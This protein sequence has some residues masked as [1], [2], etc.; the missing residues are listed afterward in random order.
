MLSI[1]YRDL[2]VVLAITIIWGFNLIVARIGVDG[3]PPILFAALRFAI[4]ALV[5]APWLRSQPGRG[6]QL[7][8]AALL[9]GALHFAALF[10][11]LAQA[12]NVAAVAIVGQL[13]IP[14]TTLLSIALLG[15]QVRWRRWSGIALAFC[16]VLLLGFDPLVLQSGASIVWVAVSAFLG[17][18]GLIAVKRL[19]PIR[20]L[21]LQAWVAWL[22][23]PVLS[24]LS[25]VIERPDLAT[26]R[27]IEPRS[28]WAAAF[29]A[30]AA[31]VI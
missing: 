14:F 11:G 2:G 21:E 24:L 26:L 7:G 19:G 18:L 29:T 1:A 17:S 3:V 23:L 16:G 30:I 15:E 27:S 31:T 8:V 4:A 13:S 28:W 20:P 6:A 12:G 22:S 5:L 25:I 10:V 9:M